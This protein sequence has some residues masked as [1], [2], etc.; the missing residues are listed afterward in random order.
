[1][2]TK[3]FAWVRREAQR[4]YETYGNN[5]VPLRG[6]IDDQKDT[7]V[8]V[9]AD[10]MRVNKSH[11]FPTPMHYFAHCLWWLVNEGHL[12]MDL[13]EVVDEARTD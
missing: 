13:N 12:S 10:W 8:F 11:V 7:W 5:Q 1:M 3:A 9:T 4:Y 2:N 6:F